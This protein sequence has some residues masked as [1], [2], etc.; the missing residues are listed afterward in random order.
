[1]LERLHFVLGGRVGEGTQGSDCIVAF[2]LKRRVA[3]LV[4]LGSFPCIDYRRGTTT[5]STLFH[6]GNKYTTATALCIFG[7]KGFV[8]RKPKQTNETKQA[9]QRNNVP[10]R[11]CT[12]AA[13]TVIML[14]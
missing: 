10:F 6:T 9:A 13:P 5:V 8:N 14:K 4:S 11:R 3:E 12:F 2:K 7:L 1:M